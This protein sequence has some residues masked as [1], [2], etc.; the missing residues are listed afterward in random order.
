M[1]AEEMTA[2][3]LTQLFRMIGITFDESVLTATAK[4]AVHI[5]TG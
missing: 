2:T 3:L 1:D 5:K 4:W